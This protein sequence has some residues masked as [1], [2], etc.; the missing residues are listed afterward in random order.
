MASSA[1]ASIPTAEPSSVQPQAVSTD[2]LG[3]PS[4]AQEEPS[5]THSA[6]TV[7]TV[8]SVSGGQTIFVT[9][10]RDV[11]PTSQPDATPAP[12]QPGKGAPVGAIAG[13]V[14]G[15]VVV[16]IVVVLLLFLH[17]RKKRTTECERATRPPSYPRGDMSEHFGPGGVE[18]DGKA[19]YVKDARNA[20]PQLDGRM[21]RPSHEM[22]AD[23]VGNI[24]EL[25]AQEKNPFKTPDLSGGT[26]LS[27]QSRKPE[28]KGEDN[29]EHAMGWSQY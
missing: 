8:A 15:G 27:F 12:P 28:Q 4:S 6:T 20:V 23:P 25:A 26:E 29:G 9:V 7:E 17:R 10:T 21:I 22:G 3:Q 16:I 24:S 13:G 18:N 14:V 2:L 5:A 19:G 11:S 1:A